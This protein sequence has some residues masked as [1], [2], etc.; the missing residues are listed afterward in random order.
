[1]P[2]SPAHAAKLSE[3]IECKKQFK[4]LLESGD[5]ESIKQKHAEI[6]KLFADLK[7]I[8]DSPGANH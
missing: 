6:K 2:L 7:Q 5:K 1:M 3:I 8:L 4:L